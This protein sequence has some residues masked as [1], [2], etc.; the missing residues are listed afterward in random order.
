M[1]ILA[2]FG[3]MLFLPVVIAV[4]RTRD[5]DETD[6]YAEYEEVSA[7]DMLRE[8]AERTLRKEFAARA[9][10]E[11]ERQYLLEEGDVSDPQAPGRGLR[12]T[13]GALDGLRARARVARLEAEALALVAD[14]AGLR[15][16]DAEVAATEL[17][18][19]LERALKEV[20]R[21]A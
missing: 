19:E 8:R 1:V 21:A 17:E 4:M 5:Q 2:I 6:P 7:A 15:A 9:A 13:R 11:E 10:A 18:L 3:L 14:A 12:D 16:D 20:W